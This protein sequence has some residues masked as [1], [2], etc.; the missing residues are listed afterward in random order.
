MFYWLIKLFFI[1]CMQGRVCITLFI[2]W[3]DCSWVFPLCSRFPNPGCLNQ[4]T[5][6]DTKSNFTLHLTCQ[7]LVTFLLK[8]KKDFLPSMQTSG[9][10]SLRKWMA[11]NIT[12]KN[13]V[14]SALCEFA[15]LKS[16]LPLL[17][18]CLWCAVGFFYF[19]FMISCLYGVFL[20]LVINP[21]YCYCMH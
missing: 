16:V 9:S 18:F 14:F 1:R 13:H 21:C 19:F 11:V 20:F 3:S 15:V 6:F 4:L 12:Q 10:N 5:F 8:K 2:Y 7:F 17:Q